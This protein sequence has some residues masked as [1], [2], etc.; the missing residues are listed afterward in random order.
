MFNL[1]KKLNA[2][3]KAEIV[4]YVKDEYPN[5]YQRMKLYWEI[6]KSVPQL[7]KI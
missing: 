5:E 6:R 2:S 1:L 7:P 3:R 4:Q